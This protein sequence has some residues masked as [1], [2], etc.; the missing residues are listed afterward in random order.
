MNRFR[1]CVAATLI[2]C[3]AGLGLP[4]PASAAMVPTDSA[5]SAGV[6]DR[7]ATLLE[8]SDVRAQLQALGVSPSEVK[9]RVA[10]MSDDE[11]AQVAGKLDSLPAGGDAAGAIVG[12]AI[13][14]FII[15]LITDI[16][17]L[18]HVFPFTKPMKR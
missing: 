12:A 8:R 14:V 15:L 13:L 7:I 1:S 6:K 4:L 18:T 2:V 9:A 17:G 10:A 3:V 16:L 11:A 5:V